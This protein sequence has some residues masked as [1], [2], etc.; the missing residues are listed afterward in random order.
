[1]ATDDPIRASDVDREA[2]VATLREA[3]MAGRLTMDEFD[4]RMTAAYNGRTW[5]DLRELTTD[6]PAQP[7]LGTDVPSRSLVPTSGVPAQP[8][9]GGDEAE[10]LE[11]PA[12]PA[13]RRPIGVL[14]PLAIWALLVVHNAVAPG[15]VFLLIAVFA[16][17]SVMASIRR[18]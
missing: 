18:R 15:T 2:V 4:E 6:L 14:V 16:V 10:Q 1:M 8:E 3:Y 13:R 12:L 9:A 7:L 11:D 5:G 17:I